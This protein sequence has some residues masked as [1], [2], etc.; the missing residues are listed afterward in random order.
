MRAA[1]LL[2]IL[3]FSVI[4]PVPRAALASASAEASSKGATALPA[5]TASE[6]E[7]MIPVKLVQ[8]AEA[9]AASGASSY[10]MFGLGA[11]VLIAG[12]ALW[13]IKRYS[14]KGAEGA[15]NKIKVLTQH[16]LGPRK[17]LAIIQVAGESVLVGITDHHISLI[18]PLSLLDD[19]IP[20]L[21]GQTFQNAA[22]EVAVETAL[23]A[24]FKTDVRDDFR[25]TDLK[26]FGRG[27]K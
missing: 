26:Q 4:G 27:L 21:E 22:N 7:S 3:S 1:L 5:V 2:F 10:L 8:K 23:G 15:K 20:E 24:V 19:E 9:G 6:Q 13:F 12:A 11:I 17:S 18:K 16:H 25:M 14:V